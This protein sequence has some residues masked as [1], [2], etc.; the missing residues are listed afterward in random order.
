M[1]IMFQI[2][3]KKKIFKSIFNPRIKIKNIRIFRVVLVDNY[4]KTLFAEMKLI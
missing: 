4:V 3:D 2:I 1:I